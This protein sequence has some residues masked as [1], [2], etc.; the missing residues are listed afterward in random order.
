MKAI[1]IAGIDKVKTPGLQ[2]VLWHKDSLQT[3]HLQQE[4]FKMFQ[5]RGIKRELTACDLEELRQL[6]L[7]IEHKQWDWDTYLKWLEGVSALSH[8]VTK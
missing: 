4:F 7:L 8:N 1:D 6:R 5:L 3:L 2:T